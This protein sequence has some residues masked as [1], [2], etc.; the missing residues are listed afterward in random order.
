L[1]LNKISK[2]K[3]LHWLYLS[4]GLALLVAI[5]IPFTGAALSP[6]RSLASVLFG[7]WGQY[8]SYWWLEAS[9]GFFGPII[10]AILA[11]YLNQKTNKK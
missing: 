7:S 1:N 9:I 10:G 11:S 6:V 8:G 4:L 5:G 3:Q 2:V